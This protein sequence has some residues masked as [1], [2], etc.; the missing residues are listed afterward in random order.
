M[1]A[2]L[3]RPAEYPPLRALLQIVAIS[4]GHP[5]HLVSLAR[6]I[7]DRGAIRTRP[8]GEHFLDTTAL[9]ALPPSA[10]GPWLAARELA[11]HR[12]ELIALARVCAVLGDE[13]TRAEVA[14]VLDLV[15]RRGG[16]TTTIDVDVGLAE[17]AAAAILVPSGAGWAFRQALLQEG[18]Y[19]TT[20]EDERTALHQAALELWSRRDRRELGVAE[21]VARHAEAVGEL[22]VAARAFATLGERAHR[23]HRPLEA[24]QAWQGA[25]RNL[26][27]RDLQRGRALLGRARARYRL[28]RVRDALADLEDALA[29]AIELADARLEVEVLL[30]RATALDWIDDYAGSAVAT[31]RA[32]TRY[33]D[34]TL[35][36]LTP[37]VVL[38]RARVVFRQARAEAVPALEDAAARAR[39]THHEETEAIALALLG[40]AL[41]EAKELVRAGSRS[42]RGRPPHGDP[43]RPRVRP[44]HDRADRDLQPR[45][46]S[47]VARR[48]RRGDQA[49]PPRSVAAAR[50]RR[51][52]DLGRRALARARAGRA[53]RGRRDPPPAIADRGRG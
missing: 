44:G 42:R 26:D 3:L 36:E 24:D 7:H 5:L 17:L 1:T 22:R 35:A 47:A 14:A 40:G 13:F 49:R 45:R 19:A 15:E 20:N 48:P 6:E 25:V 31:E 46:G 43:A 10:L 4:H 8:N 53:R 51:G 2:A 30:E 21:R 23:A 34:A 33:A 11:G 38:A 50:P 52:L 27:V 41:V 12:V 16:A 28:Q 37:E 9:D 29:I 32:A 39:R 18:V